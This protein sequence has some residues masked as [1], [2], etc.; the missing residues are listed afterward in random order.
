M[1]RRRPKSPTR[2]PLALL[3]QPGVRLHGWPTP[4]KGIPTLGLLVILNNGTRA[5]ARSLPTDRPF[6]WSSGKWEG[7]TLVVQTSDFRDHLCLDGAGNPTT[8][9]TVPT[10]R[11]R[12]VTFGPMENR[13]DL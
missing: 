1:K 9:A 7:D 11:F 10:E 12:R 6:G 13:G 5:I 4:K 8:D 3:C 2:S